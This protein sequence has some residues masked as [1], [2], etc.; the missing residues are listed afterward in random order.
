MT[1]PKGFDIPLNDSIVLD[2]SC[3]LKIDK[4]KSLQEYASS[5]HSPETVRN[6]VDC[7]D[8]DRGPSPLIYATVMHW[9][10]DP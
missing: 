5:Y 9:S 10:T 4:N 7:I 6:Q 1:P 3:L 2:K 8:S